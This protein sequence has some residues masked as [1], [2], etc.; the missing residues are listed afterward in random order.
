MIFYKVAHKTHFYFYDQ[1][2]GNM[3]SDCV[4]R[5]EKIVDLALIHR[6]VS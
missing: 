5:I 3:N 1:L 2:F 4:I 6:I